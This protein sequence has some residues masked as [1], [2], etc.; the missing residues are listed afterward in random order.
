MPAGGGNGSGAGGSVSYSIGQVICASTSGIGGL[1]TQGVQ[2]SYE[3][4]IESGIE[5][6]KLISLECTV[7][8]NPVSEYIDLKVEGYKVE[9]LNFQLY[10]L[11]GKLLQNKKV[12]G[13]SYGQDEATERLCHPRH[14]A[15]T[16]HVAATEPDAE[17]Q[18]GDKS[19]DERK[20]YIFAHKKHPELHA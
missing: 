9:N 14:R 7:F 16:C 4:F 11:N 17:E 12:E 15:S 13:I 6:A 10:D 1:I 19:A 5:A 8:P 18:G 2:Q 3:I 20:A